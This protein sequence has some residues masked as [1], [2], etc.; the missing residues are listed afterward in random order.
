MNSIQKNMRDFISSIGFLFKFDF[1]S[2]E[3][4]QNW[5]KLKCKGK[6]QSDTRKKYSQILELNRLWTNKTLLLLIKFLYPS[7][8]LHKSF[9]RFGLFWCCF[10]VYFPPYLSC[11][12][13]HFCWYIIR[14]SYSFHQWNT[15]IFIYENYFA[16]IFLFPKLCLCFTTFPN[17]EWI[18]MF[19]SENE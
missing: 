9:N 17:S 16:P 12:W 6:L 11:G 13:T 18:Q 19:L 1:D 7:L 4:E 2:I 10:D 3:S 5:I 8:L 14:F 15:I